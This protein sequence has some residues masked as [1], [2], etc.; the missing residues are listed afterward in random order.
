MTG[1]TESQGQGLSQ[2]FFQKSFPEQEELLRRAKDGGKTEK[3]AETG[4]R[5]SK[6][7]EASVQDFKQVM[8]SM[9]R[10]QAGVT[11]GDETTGA[12]ASGRARGPRGDDFWRLRVSG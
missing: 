1:V 3:A 12:V 11:A 6:G 5:E 10:Q 7:D 4:L 8:Q 2:I 9:L